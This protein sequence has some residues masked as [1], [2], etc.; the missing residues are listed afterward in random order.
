MALIQ[1][2][3]SQ[4][5]TSLSIGIFA[6]FLL[7][8]LVRSW[9]HIPHDYANSYFGAYFL[10]HGHFDLSIFDPFSF[11]KM[12]FDA[13]FRQVF[14]SYNPNPPSTAVLF[15]PFAILPLA[16]SKLIFNIISCILF[17]ISLYRISRHLEIEIY[18]PFLVVPLLFVVPIRNQILFGQ[19]YFLLFFL[20]T[21][22]YLA[23]I[24]GKYTLSSILFSMAIFL[25]IFPAIV[26]LFFIG[27]R[28]F[29]AGVSL[30]IVSVA[31]LLAFVLLQGHE[32]WMYYIAEVLPRNLSGE[33]SSA[34]EVNYQSANIFLKYLFLKHPDLNPV[35]LI[36]SHAL[37]YISD[38]VL[39]SVIIAFCV[40]LILK[41]ADLMA[42]GT[43]LF[44]SMLISSYGS[45]YG[46]LLLIFILLPAIKNWTRQQ[47]FIAG[48]LI[49]VAGNMPIK[50]FAT[51]PAVLQFPRLF[52]LIGL[53]GC[54]II[55]NHSGI[56]W[57][58]LLSL[59]VIFSIPLAR[60]NSHTD[61]S[62]LL[63]KDEMN[64]ITYDY[65]SK[66][67][68]LFYQYWSETGSNIHI[69]KIKGTAI[70]SLRIQLI[71]NQIIFDNKQLTTSRD[72]K[73]KPM[74]L[75]EHTILYLSD[76]DNGIGFYSLRK[77]TI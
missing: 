12:I 11:N 36:D 35:P 53:L 34:Y 10:V 8:W 38:I 32:V 72:K 15:L 69:T 3:F 70:K 17:A 74:L 60:L 43:L 39:K 29:K 5:K 23:S 73:L 56:R 48:F 55:Y 4:N 7:Y 40:N 63:C 6:A 26:I 42:F 57:G 64:N 59:L 75:D 44:G 68:Y 52:V 76:K 19:T 65:G 2:L 77:L 33:I 49:L 20:L 22:G 58:I 28:N 37:F 54:V 13:G 62:T 50:F 30:A 1:K 41:R 14:V 47:I 45:T 9:F 61:N 16:I 25:K 46:N 67:G 71:N 66:N 31:M 24:N 51:L 27:A 21:E 18:I